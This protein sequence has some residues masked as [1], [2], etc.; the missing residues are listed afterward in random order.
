[1]KIKV[2]L[3]DDQTIVRDGLKCLLEGEM[4]IQVAGAAGNGRDAVRQ[5]SKLRPDVAV[6]DIT[7]REL[8]GIDAT[9]QIV[10]NSPSTRVIILSAHAD[11]PNVIRAFKAGASGYV[12]KD[13]P[14]RELVKAIRTVLRGGRHLSAEISE[15]VV[16]DYILRRG[17]IKMSDLLSKLS[18]RE[19]EV[20][21][22][23]VQG[24]T[25]REMGAMLGLSPKTVN[26][27]RYRLMEKL[28]IS[29]IPGLVRFGI[30]N[31]LAPWSELPRYAYNDLQKDT[32]LSYI[33]TDGEKL[34][35]AIRFQLTRFAAD[36]RRLSDLA[37]SSSHGGSVPFF[38]AGISSGTFPA[39]VRAVNHQKMN[40]RAE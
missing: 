36:L 3:A 7:L 37:L 17:Q 16:E 34:K 12:A 5:V 21:G 9:A 23:I 18:G 40:S 31:G 15:K 8:N 32:I 13:S 35:C 38:R 1:L 29:D 33:Q 24:R 19:R 30:R 22:L 10:E 11:L 6:L 14:G 25:S 28:C 4:D 2:F 26:T 39:D 20:L 27:Y